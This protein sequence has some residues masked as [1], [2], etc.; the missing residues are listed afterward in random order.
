MFLFTDIIS[1]HSELKMWCFGNIHHCSIE[2][3]SDAFSSFIIFQKVL[4]ELHTRYIPKVSSILTWK[5][6]Y[7]VLTYFLPVRFQLWKHFRNYSLVTCFVD[8]CGHQRTSW[9]T[10][11]V[12]CSESVWLSSFWPLVCTRYK[13]STV[14]DPFWNISEI[15]YISGKYM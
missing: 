10:V 13:R 1:H 2:R 6:G 14:E 8:C 12:P 7:S 15:W 5:S 11:I 3:L 4:Y 9:L